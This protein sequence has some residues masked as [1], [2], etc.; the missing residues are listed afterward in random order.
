MSGNSAI[1]LANKR[2]T[3]KELDKALDDI[4]TGRIK[5]HASVNGPNF[6]AASNKK[7]GDRKYNHTSSQPILDDVLELPDAPNTLSASSVFPASG[8]GPWQQINNPR[9]GQSS[10]PIR[11]DAL[12]LPDAPSTHSA[13]SFFP[14]PGWRPQQTNNP[15]SGQLIPDDVLELPDAPSVIPTGQGPWP[16][17]RAYERPAL[18]APNDRRA[19]ILPFGHDSIMTDASP[20][21]ERR[22]H[23]RYDQNRLPMST[24]PRSDVRPADGFTPSSP[25]GK[26]NQPGI[27]VPTGPRSNIDPINNNPQ[28]FPHARNNQPI[29]PAPT[30]PRSEVQ[31]APNLIP[32]L[33]P[34]SS[35]ES[36]YGKSNKPGMAVPTEPRSNSRPECASSTRNAQSHPAQSFAQVPSAQVSQQAPQSSPSS[37]PSIQTPRISS[38]QDS[39]QASRS[40]RDIKLIRMRIVKNEVTVR[41]GY[42]FFWD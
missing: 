28:A 29:V 25:H 17:V 8:R 40:Q 21:S 13:S 18:W 36:P 3:S 30:E 33:A 12:E 9:K 32:A 6:I 11:D 14:T 22:P 4:I 10:K 5:L 27:P 19:Q 1:N 20:A 26:S 38:A 35:P 23:E 24:G 42:A 31:P 15:R 41:S 39:T 16:P 2:F 37:S 34:Q 7:P